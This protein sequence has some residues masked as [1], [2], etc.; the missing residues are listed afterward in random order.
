MTLIRDIKTACSAAKRVVLENME[1]ATEKTGKMNPYGDETLLLDKKAEDHAVQI[2]QES[3]TVYSIL[4]EE[5]G[6]IIPKMKPE[7]LAIIDPIDGSTNLERGIP[8]CCIGISIIPFKD[9]MTTTPELR[10][11]SCATA[12]A[13]RMKC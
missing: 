12:S 10:H 4:T 5:R 13:V 8:L 7:Y 11:T 3:S 6:L 9:S 1:I 2:L